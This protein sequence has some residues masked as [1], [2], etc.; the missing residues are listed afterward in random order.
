LTSSL[1]PTLDAAD[2]FVDEAAI[3]ACKLPKSRGGPDKL[4]MDSYD[5]YGYSEYP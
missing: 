3:F 5:N 4:G 2:P 1:S